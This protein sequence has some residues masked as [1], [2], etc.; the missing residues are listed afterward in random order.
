[1]KQQIFWKGLD[2]IGQA[3]MLLPLV[4]LSLPEMRGYAMVTYFS[5][6]LWQA[7]SCL[8]N[9]IVHA[10]PSNAARRDY[11]HFLGWTAGIVLGTVAIAA[12]CDAV[13]GPAARWTALPGAV[14][15]LEGFCL[16]LIS[17]FTAIWY[18]RLTRNELAALKNAMQHRAE[19]HWK[20]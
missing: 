6:G 1:M 10:A 8:L 12:F 16:L 5:L 17:P 18:A 11:E 20:L 9:R 13:G 14:G 2:L 4:C 3:L 15:L 7:G 19:I